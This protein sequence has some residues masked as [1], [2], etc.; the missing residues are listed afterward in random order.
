ML[1]LLEILHALGSTGDQGKIANLL[2]NAVR[3]E[4]I[5]GYL[6]NCGPRALC[7]P[8]KG[9]AKKTT[10]GTTRQPTCNTYDNYVTTLSGRSP[11]IFWTPKS[12][13][14]LNLWILAL[15]STELW[16]GQGLELV[17]LKGAF[18]QANAS[19]ASRRQPCRT[20]QCPGAAT[21]VLG[22]SSSLISKS[23]RMSWSSSSPCDVSSRSEED[24]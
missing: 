18:A 7:G 15:A 9:T 14:V 22:P 24:V 4:Q 1:R 12:P 17:A 23:A 13:Q 11:P 19:T 10:R 8:S 16:P 20:W 21:C 6:A 2:P 5:R 3:S